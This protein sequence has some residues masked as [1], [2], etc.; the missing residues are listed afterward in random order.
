MS[1]KFMNIFVV[2]AREIAHYVTLISN[3]RVDKI[4]IW[5]SMGR[6][7]G[8]GGLNATRITNE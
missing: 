2:V 5:I 1:S 7:T 4:R 3:N 8:Q 6:K